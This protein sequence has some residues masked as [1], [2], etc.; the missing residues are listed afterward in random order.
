MDLFAPEGAIRSTF[1][2]PSRKINFLAS[3]GAKNALFDPLIENSFFWPPI[4]KKIVYNT[5]KIS[6]FLVA[7]Y[8]IV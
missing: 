7:Q 2:P 3:Q 5:G 8:T 1:W 4:R 6:I